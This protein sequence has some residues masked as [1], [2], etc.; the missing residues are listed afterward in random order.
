MK[1]VRE[2]KTQ[3]KGGQFRS[4]TVSCPFYK[5]ESHCK[6]FCSGIIENTSIHLAFGNATD[7][8]SHK[9]KFCKNNYAQCYIHRMLDSAYKDGDIKKIQ[10]SKNNN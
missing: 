2:V 7:W 3:M 1:N 8:C 6:I 9:Q 10:K 5:K 4:I